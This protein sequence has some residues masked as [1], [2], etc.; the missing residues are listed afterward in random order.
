MVKKMDD[1]RIRLIDDRGTTLVEMIV[2]F[3]LLAIFISAA[4]VIIV[5]MTSLYYEVK[6]ELYA[7]QVSDIVIEK[8]SSEIDGAIYIDGDTSNNPRI[9]DDINNNKGTSIS[10]VDK[11]D[12]SV[13]LSVEDERLVIEYMDIVDSE[14]SSNDR[15]ATTW[16]FDEN[17]YNGFAVSDFEL[18]RG[19]GLESE[20]SKIRDYGIDG[21]LDDYDDNIILVLITLDSPKYGEYKS[22]RFVKMYNVPTSTTVPNSNP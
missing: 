16:K 20:E 1:N 18:I 13:M 4:T 11:T 7:K 2:C 21:S 3:A 12:T 19:D 5:A 9:D 10:L 17:V 15:N 8:I 22:Y 14:D 6:G